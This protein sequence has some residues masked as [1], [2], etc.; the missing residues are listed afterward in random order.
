MLG[1][2]SPLLFLDRDFLEPRGLVPRRI[3]TRGKLHE[4]TGAYRILRADRRA[5]A[6][7]HVSQVYLRY[8][9]LATGIHLLCESVGH[10]VTNFLRTLCL[11]LAQTGL[12]FL[13]S[14]W[15][16]RTSRGG[17]WLGTC[18]R[19]LRLGA[20]SFLESVLQPF[21]HESVLD[22]GAHHLDATKIC[23]VRIVVLVCF[24]APVKNLLGLTILV[25]VEAFF[26]EQLLQTFELVSSVTLK[27]ILG[28]GTLLAA[29]R[30]NVQ[31]VEVVVVVGDVDFKII[32]V[33]FGFLV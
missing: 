2:R 10:E 9:A 12:P 3:T 20:T 30:R 33:I 16:R 4:A 17:G 21:V 23:L 31:V 26:S 27:V 5:C 18:F 15:F 7:S 25:T 19:L 29:D 1:H 22:I 32:I 6:L 24:P 13:L 28:K 11:H 14:L 8:L